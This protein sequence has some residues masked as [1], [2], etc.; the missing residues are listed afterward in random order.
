MKKTIVVLILLLLTP[1][2]AIHADTIKLKNLKEAIEAK[3]IELTQDYVG[4]VIPEKDIKSVTIQPNVQQAYPDIVSLLPSGV[5]LECKVTSI[6]P[7]NIGVRIPKA[8]VISVHMVFAPEITKGEKEI[9]QTSFSQPAK[10]ILSPEERV[11][12]N[13]PAEGLR[14]KADP[15]RSGTSNGAEEK[16]SSS[17]LSFPQP[18]ASPQV[19]REA[20]KEKIK[21]DVI[22]ELEAEKAPKEEA[23]PSPQALKEEIKKEL[24]E[25]IE[26]KREAEEKVF[27]ETNLGRV[28][29]R[30]LRKGQPLPDCEV[31]IV[32]LVSTKIPFAKGYSELP[33]EYD[34]I[35]DSEGRYHLINVAPGEYKIYWKPS[36]ESGWIRRISME[37]DIIVESGKTTYPKD[38]ETFK[39]IIN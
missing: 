25:E 8:E 38:I 3:I 27:Q 5:K 1:C 34:G 22:Q 37:P 6:N 11:E 15:V 29:G 2:I 13:K 21:R 28:E 17:S 36:T 33:T 16:D 4:V 23:W 35:T 30:I 24:K 12:Q 39:R 14:L 10:P 26:A 31:R 20:A 18:L 9:P 32:M 19:S 7:D